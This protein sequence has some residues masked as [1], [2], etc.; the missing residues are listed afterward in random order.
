MFIDRTD[1]GQQLAVA[2]KQYKRKNNTV[3]V[4]LPRGGVV[5]GYA[6]ANTLHL[7]LDMLLVKKIGHPTNSEFAIG[8]VSLTGRISKN[9]DNA[10]PF[11]INLVKKSNGKLYLLHAYNLPIVPIGY[12]FSFNAKME[13]VENIVSEIRLNAHDKLNQL[14]KDHKLSNVEHRALLREGDVKDEILY[15]IEKNDIDMVIMGTRGETAE[16]GFFMGSTTKS[17]I[18]NAPCPIFAIPKEAQFKPSRIEYGTK[19]VYLSNLK[20]DETNI[21]NH[22]IDFAKLYDVSLVILHID[23]EDEELFIGKNGKSAIHEWSI[24][25]LKDIINKVVY[26]KI[27]YKEMINKNIIEGINEW[28]SCRH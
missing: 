2:L 9:A 20:Y 1:A 4:A 6:I 22:I 23:Y 17:I 12:S 7:P 8:A 13:R 14:I 19:I 24:E 25:L 28:F 26:P 18:Q 15:A 3:V 16:K 5:L 10:L 21:I 27:S 11:A